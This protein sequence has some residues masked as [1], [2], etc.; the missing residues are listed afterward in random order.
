[1]TP[2]P[3]TKPISTGMGFTLIGSELVAFT[4]VGVGLDYWLGSLP[5]LTLVFTLLGMGAAVLFTMRLLKQEEAN[6]Q[7]PTT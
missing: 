2:R 4:L 7:R 1:M 5:W 6:K 3:N